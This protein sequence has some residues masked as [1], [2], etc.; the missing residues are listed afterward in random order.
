M[1]PAEEKREFGPV[2]GGHIVSGRG[3]AAFFTGLDWVVEQCREKLGFT[4]WPGT[5]NL[6]VA[7]AVGR[8]ILKAA[9]TGLELVPAD[10]GFCSARVLSA[11][12]GKLPVAVIIPA[13]EVRRHNPDTIEILAPVN[14]RHTLD[15]EDDD[16]IELVLETRAGKQ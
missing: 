2:I 8:L 3:E 13:A 16:F 15:K 7:P 6:K 11:R 4:P 10:P 1:N 14:L 5:L 9:K 12:I